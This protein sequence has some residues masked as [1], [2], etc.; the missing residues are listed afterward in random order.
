MTDHRAPTPMYA[1][2]LRLRHL[3]PG[4]VACFFF[5]EGAIALAGLLILADKVSAWALLVLPL[6][7]ALVVK[8]N[9]VV[10]G[11]MSGRG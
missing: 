9:D 3:R 8:L 10:A 11:A 2:W 6:I 5:L 1:R 7:V 4:S